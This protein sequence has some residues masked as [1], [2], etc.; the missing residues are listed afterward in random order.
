MGMVWLMARPLVEEHDSEYT[1]VRNTIEC[2]IQ[3][4]LRR[5]LG[6]RLSPVAHYGEYHDRLLKRLYPS[7]RLEVPIRRDGIA[8]R[9]DAIDGGRVIEHKV[10]AAP[11][12]PLL[13]TPRVLR[14]IARGVQDIIASFMPVLPSITRPGANGAR[15]N[16]A[17]KPSCVDNDPFTIGC[18][19]RTYFGVELSAKEF[20][21]R[22]RR[23]ITEHIY[24][25][26]P[27]DYGAL[28]ELVRGA[29]SRAGG[30][31]ANRMVS[32]IAVGAVQAITY[33][34]LLGGGY[35]PLLSL[36]IVPRTRLLPIINVEFNLGGLPSDVYDF[37]RAVEVV[38]NPQGFKPRE[39][40]GLKLR[41]CKYCDLKAICPFRG[42]LERFDKEVLERDRQITNMVITGVIERQTHVHGR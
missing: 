25:L 35:N 33:N 39:V 9:V 31:R 17:T 36:S 22:T 3:E 42:E 10:V 15:V 14:A 13:A 12:T 5:T 26:P 8:G 4:Y 27:E 18:I 2:P 32:T 7:A 38:R 20:Y 24:R 30:D 6:Y 21:A 11:V 34:K 23:Y 37:G 28:A 29:P 16:N 19:A 40:A 41:P 1:W